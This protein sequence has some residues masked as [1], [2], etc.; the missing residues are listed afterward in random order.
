MKHTAD[1]AIFKEKMK[2]TFAYRQKMVHDPRPGKLSAKQA[3]DYLVKFN[4][5]GTSVQGHLDSITESLQP[6]LLAVGT[7][8]SGIH[9]YFIVIDEHAIPYEEEI[10]LLNLVSE[11]QRKRRRWSVHPLNDDRHVG[12]RFHDLAK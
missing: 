8:R 10:V 2:Q 12:G 5:T 4:K 1:E 9:K 3:S 7:Q 11:K 6:Y